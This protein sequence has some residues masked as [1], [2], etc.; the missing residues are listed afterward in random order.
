MVQSEL[1]VD[2]FQLLMPHLIDIMKIEEIDNIFEEMKLLYDEC[3]AIFQ[4]DSILEPFSRTVVYLTQLD[5]D[6]LVK[7]SRTALKKSPNNRK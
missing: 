5:K 2:F 7:K 4:K 1:V 6:Y 3:S